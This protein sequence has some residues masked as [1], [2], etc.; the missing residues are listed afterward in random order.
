MQDA[1]HTWQHVTFETQAI[2]DG[3]KNLKYGQSNK[4]SFGTLGAADNP[5]QLWPPPATTE[6]RKPKELFSTALLYIATQILDHVLNAT[7]TAQPS[8]PVVD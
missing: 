1:K 5:T 7:E 6:V 2:A 8:A 4:V 3:C